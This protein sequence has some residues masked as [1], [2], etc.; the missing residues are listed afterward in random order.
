MICITEH[1]TYPSPPLK[2]GLIFENTVTF[3]KRDFNLQTTNIPLIAGGSWKPLVNFGLT[4]YREF[5]KLKGC[6]TNQ[7]TNP[8]FLR[9][10]ATL[11]IFMKMGP[12]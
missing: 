9:E 2:H 1:P 8:I 6:S 10:S 7:F 12:S 4:Y 5:F 3:I 11:T